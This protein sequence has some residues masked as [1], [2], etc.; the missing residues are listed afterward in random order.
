MSTKTL[1]FSR[2]SYYHLTHGLV[3]A[4]LNTS[5][6]ILQASKFLQVLRND[7]NY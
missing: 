1:N 5:D 3:S 2:E 4:S 6:F 7:F